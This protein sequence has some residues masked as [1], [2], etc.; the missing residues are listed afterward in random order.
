MEM[1]SL[2]LFL[3]SILFIIAIILWVFSLLSFRKRK[4]VLAVILAVIGLIIIIPPTYVTFRMFGSIK[5][6]N[7]TLEEYDFV[8]EFT[9]INQGFDHIYLS[10]EKT[11]VGMNL[12]IN[13]FINGNGKLSIIHRPFGENEGVFIE[14]EGNINKT[15]KNID[16]YTPECLIK[17]IPENEFVDGKILI[18]IKMY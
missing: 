6:N 16:W 10:N 17:F 4:T 13:S 15:I 9:Q 11:V 12:E 1:G 14:L 8:K 3:I 18:K 7:N 2:I 5:F